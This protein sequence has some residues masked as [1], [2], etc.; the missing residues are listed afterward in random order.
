MSEFMKFKTELEDGVLEFEVLQPKYLQEYTDERLAFLQE[1]GQFFELVEEDLDRQIEELNGK[2]DCLTNKADGYDY[3]MAICSGAIAG[4]VDI[5]F[6]G[7]FDF[8]GAKASVDEAFEKFVHNRAKDIKIDEAIEKAKE[9][10]A[11]KGEKLTKEKIAEIKAGIEKNFKDNPNLASSIKTLEEKYKIP[12]DSIW[13]G[14]G[15]GISAK[16]HHLDDLAHHPS[17]IGLAASILTQFT[18]KGYFEGE[19]GGLPFT[20]DIENK[21]LIGKDLRAKL[22]C[23]VINWIGHLISD[24]AGS[25]SSARKGNPGMG[26][27]GPFVTTLKELGMLP[28]FKKMHFSEIANHLFTDDNAIFGQFRLDLRSEL[29]IGKELTKQA[30]PV[31]IDEVL[32]RTGFFVRHF[33][34]HA[35][36]A[37]SLTDIPWKEILPAGNRTIARMVTISLGTMEVIDITDA[38]IRG[39]IEADKAGAVGAEAGAVG[40][41]YGAAAGAATASTVAFW[42]TFALRVN[43]VG[44]GSFA[45]AGFI[46]T[47]MGIKRQQFLSERIAMYDKKLAVSNAKVCFKEAE[48]W[49]S[50]EQAGITIEEAY[51]YIE[52]AEKEINDAVANIIA[53]LDKIGEHIDA[54][55]EKNPGLKESMLDTLK[56]G[57]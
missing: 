24:M 54:A 44:V 49:I 56:W 55:E 19:E 16:T 36:T 26:L 31:F 30:I 12:S 8:K 11:K 42:K 1:Q 52:K 41:P 21:E 10:Y 50:A 13:N 14:K 15:L 53:N 7:E 29:A 32:V 33:L 28:I 23:G 39:A 3:A 34:E 27:P 51:S 35:K 57:I 5:F 17:I 2:I 46:D 48:M 20:I 43:Y 9:N 47:S 22:V 45:V 25:S 4:L 40:G 18:K 38:A 37:Q 6:V